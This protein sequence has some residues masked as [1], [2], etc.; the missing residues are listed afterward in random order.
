V[1]RVRKVTRAE[2]Q[3]AARRYLTGSYAR[4]TF[5]PRPRTP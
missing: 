5:V 4:L 3:E 1:D 2:V